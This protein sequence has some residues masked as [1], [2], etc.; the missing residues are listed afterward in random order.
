[1]STVDG[2]SAPRY[3]GSY[4]LYFER[5]EE[6]SVQVIALEYIEGKSLRTIF[7]EGIEKFGERGADEELTKY[8]IGLVNLLYESMDRLHAAASRT[9]SPMGRNVSSKKKGKIVFS[10]FSRSRILKEF[11]FYDQEVFRDQDQMNINSL[12]ER[13]FHDLKLH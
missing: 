3:Y 12:F 8:I 10:D 5:A 4:Q 6:K 9:I 2:L 1:L 7:V 11:T 13:G